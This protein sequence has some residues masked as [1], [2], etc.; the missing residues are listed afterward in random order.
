MLLGNLAC[1]EHWAHVVKACKLLE[2][3]FPRGFF[4]FFG[5]GVRPFLLE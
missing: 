4:F 3:L 5:F 2:T 1:M